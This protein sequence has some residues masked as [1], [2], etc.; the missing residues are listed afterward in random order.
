MK[1][2]SSNLQSNTL[3]DILERVLDKG[4]VIAGDITVTIGEVELLSIKIRLIIASVDKA[5]EMGI[6][7]WR[8]DQMLSSLVA[9]TGPQASLEQERKQLMLELENERLRAELATLKRNRLAAEVVDEIIE[10][11]IVKPDPLKP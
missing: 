11:E 8:T 3:A 2:T 6:D 7:W 10:G 4:V 5:K 1:P 9:E